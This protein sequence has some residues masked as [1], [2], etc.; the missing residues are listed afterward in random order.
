[1]T[2][3]VDWAKVILE[4]KAKSGMN[5]QAIAVHCQLQGV[6]GVSQDSI[7]KLTYHNRKVGRDIRHQ[8]G[9]VLLC[10]LEKVKEL[11]ARAA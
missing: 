10:L 11:N 5:S 7:R 8:L 3:V 2:P 9:A 1:M 4:I 6:R